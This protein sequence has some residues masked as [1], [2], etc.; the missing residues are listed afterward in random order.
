[1]KIDRLQNPVGFF[2][3]AMAERRRGRITEA[4]GGLGM[5]FRLIEAGSDAVSTAIHEST[6]RCRPLRHDIALCE[7]Q[8]RTREMAVR[9]PYFCQSSGTRRAGKRV[10]RHEEESVVS[11]PRRLGARV[12]VAE[13]GE[14]VLIAERNAA[15]GLKLERQTEGT[16]AGV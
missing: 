13:E 5:D 6:D 7:L 1:M 14:M 9:R 16:V 4:L 3:L 2:N 10:A 12:V 15:G 8:A 11:T